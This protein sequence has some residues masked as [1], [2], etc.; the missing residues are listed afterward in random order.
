MV[1]A[2]WFNGNKQKFGRDPGFGVQPTD[3]FSYDQANEYV[4]GGIPGGLWK[5]QVDHTLSR[6]FFVSVK[7]AYYDTGFSLTPRGGTD[8]TWTLDYN[9]NISV[10]SAPKYLAV[11]PQKNFTAD[12]NY[13]FQGM[14]GN[15]EL[16]MGFSWRDYK[17][18]S[19]YA[20]GGSELVGYLETENTGYVEIGRTQPEKEYVGTY[21][22]AYL[23]DTYSKD[24][25]TLNAGVRWD[26]QT[27]RNTPATVA[28][29]AA[30][31]DIMPALEY[32]GDP[33]D[34]IKWNTISP[35]VGLS[36]A[37]DDARRTVMRASYALYGGQLSFGDVSTINPVSW[38]AVAYLWTD[39]NGDKFVQPGEIDF[40]SGI[41]YSYGV[42]LSNPSSAV[43]PN[44]IDKD[45]KA[46]KDH[47]VVFG[48]DREVGPSFAVGLAGTWRRST[49]F[50]Y[51]PRRGGPCPIEDS[52]LGNCRIIQPEEYIQTDSRTANGY[53]AVAFG[54]PGALVT[55]G[56]GGRMLTNAS[57]YARTFKGLELTLTKRLTNRWMSR[58]AVS[59]ND[60]T[61]SWDGTPFSLDLDDGNPTST[62]TDPLKEGG[63]VSILSG[64]SGKASFYT[65]VNWQVYGNALW[66]GPWGLDL[67][68][69]VIARQGGAYPVALR[70]GGGAD[71][72]NSAL[73]TDEVTSLRYDTLVNVD[74]RLAKTFKF[75]S[76][77]GLTLSAEWFNVFNSDTVLGRA[78]YA[79]TAAFTSNS[80]I[81]GRGRIEEII[82]PSIF[83]FGAR[84]SF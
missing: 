66:Q 16:K 3:E 42:N 2:F 36:Y 26:L 13:F 68:G 77:T 32:G 4:E 56:Q 37:L 57:G 24:R 20:L 38:G 27:A 50:T 83:R 49:D 78:R 67:S 15:N 84:F 43:S 58:I 53:S 5:L 75:G 22:S 12:A 8:N 69:A 81:N 54:P 63:P 64:A 28:A 17:T 41:Q 19:G 72:T 21:W 51:N 31:P 18:I 70:L 6:D 7:G 40:D 30:F 1:S 65:T 23:G 34:T 71:G 80:A 45:L 9:N 10:G 76:D 48:I 73:A 35:R 25:L 55:A 61:E 52:T 47:E 82:A 79:N 29:N 59:L 62:E 74:L 14:G 60:W 44:R 46:P 33:G 39:A 11:R